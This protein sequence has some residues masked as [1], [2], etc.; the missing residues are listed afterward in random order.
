MS[1]ISDIYRLYLKPIHLPA[2]GSAREATIAGATVEELHPRPTEKKRFIVI[3]FVGKPHKFI[4]NQGNANRMYN[5]GGDDTDKW[6][7]LVI[8]LSRAT[9]GPKE[10]III[11]EPKNGKE[12]G[13]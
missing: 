10:T 7:G 13:K 1:K 12:N 5:I 3:S 8:T 6:P 4:L 2:D 11:S 9:W